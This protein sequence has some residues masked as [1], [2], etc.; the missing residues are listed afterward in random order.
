MKKKNGEVT[1]SFEEFEK[2]VEDTKNEPCCMNCEH[3]VYIGEGDSICDADEPFL[4]LDDW[5]P[6]DEYFACGGA[7]FIDKDED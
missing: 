3:C 5:D 4:I 2:F 7:D 6:T 1:M